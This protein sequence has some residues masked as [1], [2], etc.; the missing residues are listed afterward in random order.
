LWNACRQKSR[1]VDSDAARDAPLLLMT[2][3]MSNQLV[4][5]LS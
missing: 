4:V 3:F 5:L 1:H 2:F